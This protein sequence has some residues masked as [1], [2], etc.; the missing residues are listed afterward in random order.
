MKY[1]AY[2]LL[3]T[4]EKK[5]VETWDE[6]FSKIKGNKVKHKSFKTKKEAQ[7]WLENPLQKIILEKGIYFDSGTGRGIGVEVKVVNEKE[8]NLLKKV[9]PV[10]KTNK[11]GN[12]TLKGSEAHTNNFGELLGLYI[13]LKIGMQEKILKIFGDSELVIKYWSNGYYKDIHK[14]TIDLIKKVVKLKKEFTKMG[15]E[16]SKISGDDNPADLGFHK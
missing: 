16:I 2:I 1:Y 4:N 12:Y 3:E 9:I 15:G 13:A 6:C 7:Y 11:Y 14:D 8:D 5:I 10:E